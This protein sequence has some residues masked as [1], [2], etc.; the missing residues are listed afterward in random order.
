MIF[1]IIM[2]YS[3]ITLARRNVRCR[4]SHLHNVIFLFTIF[5]VSSFVTEAF[6]LDV[7]FPENVRLSAGVSTIGVMTYFAY[8][9]IFSK[10]SPWE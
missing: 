10:T 9:M 6:I 7:G 8:I 2:V 4:K 5:F 3:S 1:P